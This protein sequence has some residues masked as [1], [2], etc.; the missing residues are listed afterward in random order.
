MAFQSCLILRATSLSLKGPSEYW[1]GMIPARPCCTRGAGDRFGIPKPQE[2]GSV[3]GADRRRS[4]PSC[5]K[6]CQKAKRRVGVQY[7]PP[8]AEPERPEAV[9]PGRGVALTT[10]PTFSHLLIVNKL[11][12]LSLSLSLSR[13]PSQLTLEFSRLRLRFSSWVC[14]GVRVGG[15]RM[16]HPTAGALLRCN[17]N[18]L[19]LGAAT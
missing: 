6:A 1:K 12:S 5:R 14:P 2:S 16:Q 19:V 15:G 9:S 17:G 13:N 11:L 4:G 7:S 8:Y 3:I 18:S 10:L